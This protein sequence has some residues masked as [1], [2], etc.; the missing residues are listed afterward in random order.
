MAALVQV[1]ADTRDVPV[2]FEARK[3]FAH[4]LCLYADQ[5][6]EVRLGHGSLAVQD[7]KGDDARVGHSYTNKPLIPGMFNQAGSC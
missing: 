4:R 2:R 3:G 6:R 7:S 1:I 5:L